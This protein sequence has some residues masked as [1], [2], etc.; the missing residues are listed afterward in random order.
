LTIRRRSWNP[1][2]LPV[3]EIMAETGFRRFAYG[4]TRFLSDVLCSTG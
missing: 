2:L 1:I 4:E 3:D